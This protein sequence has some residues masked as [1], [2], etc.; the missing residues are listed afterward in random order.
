VQ[1]KHEAQTLLGNGLCVING[2]HWLSGK[3]CDIRNACALPECL[4]PQELGAT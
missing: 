1:V 2:P 4:P 3:A